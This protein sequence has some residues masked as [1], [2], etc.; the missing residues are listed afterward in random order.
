MTVPAAL[1]LSYLV[2]SIPTA[3]LLV[4]L[5]RGVDVRSVG[6]GNVG[7][8]NVVR[9]AGVGPGVAVFLVD[10]LKGAAAV[11]LLGGRVGE[12]W[13]PLACGAC[14]IVG[15]DFPVWLSFR[16]GKG[17]AT[18]IGVL[19]AAVPGA[20][21]V[22][23]LIWAVMFAA[24]RFVSAAS[25]AASLA[26]PLTVRRLDG[27]PEEVAIIAGLSVLLIWQHRANIRRLAAGTEHNTGQRG[28]GKV[29]GNGRIP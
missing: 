7:A 5:L 11:V 22:Y 14:A 29:D 13:A 25:L 6:S 17:V 24:T 4:R 10:A 12:A 26:M 2:G 18:M 16:G 8:T 20:A 21:A 3:Y 19:A 28:N 27:T 15:H 23:G 9:A 1:G